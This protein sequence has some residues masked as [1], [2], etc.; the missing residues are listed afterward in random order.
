MTHF[1]PARMVSFADFQLEEVSTMEVVWSPSPVGVYGP[2][3]RLCIEL[4]L[5]TDVD[6]SH[7]LYP[8]FVDDQFHVLVLYEALAL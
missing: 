8:H 2:T 3:V 6:F 4:Q 5:S 1:N 7:G